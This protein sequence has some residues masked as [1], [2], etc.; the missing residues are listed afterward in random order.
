MKDTVS[1]FKENLQSNQFKNFAIRKYLVISRLAILITITSV[2]Y[3]ISQQLDFGESKDIGFKKEGVAYVYTSPKNVDVFQ[4]KIRQVPGVESVGNGSSF[5]IEP[6]NQLTYKL[7]GDETVFDDSRQ[8]YLDFEAVKTYGLKTTLKEIPTIRTT[9]MNRT[10]AEKLA[11]YKKIEVNDLIGQSITTEPEY[12]DEETGEVGFPFV[13]EGIFEDINLFSPHE[14]V[15][16]YSITL[17]STVRMN[18]RSIIFCKTENEAGV[19]EKINFYCW[20]YCLQSG[21][22]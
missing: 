11:A 9:P 6:F 2:S 1:L 3:F 10:A 8:L 16:P 14:K 18:G 21:S 7:Q 5:G 22:G 12:I 19:L 17:S 13:I 15:E 4:E 20:S